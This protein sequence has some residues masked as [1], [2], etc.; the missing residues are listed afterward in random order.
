M[1]PLRS[2]LFAPG[3]HPRRLQKVGSFGS[4]AIVLDL[5]DAVADSEQDSARELV[6]IALPS[7]GQTTMVTVCVNGQESG[8]MEDDLKAVVRPQLDCVMIPKLES[9]DTLPAV[10]TLT[11]ELERERGI[12][13]RKVRILGLIETARGLTLCEEIA[14]TGTPRLLT[15][16]FGLADFSVDVG[17]DVT[18]A[19]TELL[20][21]RSRIVVAARAAGLAQPIDGPYLELQDATGLIADCGRSRCL[22]FQGRVVIYPPHVGP[23]NALTQISRMTRPSVAVESSRVSKQPKRPARP[24]S[25]SKD[26]SLTTPSTTVRRRSSDGTKP[27]SRRRQ[28]RAP[29][30]LLLSIWA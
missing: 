7:Y 11:T 2:L 3:N 8:R 20:Y 10:D 17:V 28:Y 19:G 15:L 12:Q 1:H 14:A 4:D 25:R 18:P 24:R 16:V 26:A 6:R 29:R 30:C 5:E 27:R 23:C 22:G 9:R 13:E 21:A